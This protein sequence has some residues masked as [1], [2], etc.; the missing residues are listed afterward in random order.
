MRYEQVREASFI[1]RPNRFVAYVELAGQVEL[2]HVKNT[3]RCR[4]LLLP[5]CR[6]SLAKAANPN[7]KTKYDLIAVEKPGLGW[8]NI[9]SQAPNQVVREWLQGRHGAGIDLLR[10]EYTY[11]RSRFDFYLEAA[12]K[13]VLLEVK[14]CTLEVGG[15]GYFPDAPTARGVKHLQELA[16]AVAQGYECCLAFVIA[17]PKVREVRP[18]LD[19]HPEFGAALAGARAAGVRVLYLPCEVGPA[20]LCIC[21]H[22]W[23]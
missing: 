7:R 6:V 20:E 13:R 21:D 5:G 14:G 11:G 16:A 2:V 17:M 3:G 18:N 12:G 19:T 10:P 4:E 8:V 9:D 1:Q 15:V 22:I 23:A